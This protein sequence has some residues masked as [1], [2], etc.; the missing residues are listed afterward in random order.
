M[1]YFL[2]KKLEHGS[3]SI[4]IVNR[5]EYLNSGFFRRFPVAVC[6]G[7]ARKNEIIN[8]GRASWNGER[9]IHLGV[10]KD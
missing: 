10:E 9:G 3:I 4:N 1:L 8:Q 7:C 2:S 6:R 5:T